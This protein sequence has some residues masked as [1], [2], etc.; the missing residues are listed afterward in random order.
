MSETG[1]LV[2]AVTAG[3]TAAFLWVK[4]ELWVMR[5][6]RGRGER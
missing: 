1:W 4:R 5:R 2:L 3:L 6:R